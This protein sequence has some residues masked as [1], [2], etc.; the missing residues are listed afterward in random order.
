MDKALE[1]TKRNRELEY[2][3]YVVVKGAH[4]VAEPTNPAIGNLFI[5]VINTGRTPGLNGKVVSEVEFQENPPPEST[6]INPP[7]Q[8]PSKSVFAP[9]IEFLKLAGS[10]PTDEARKIREA[11]TQQRQA[12]SSESPKRAS[13]TPRPIPSPRVYRDNRKI[14]VYGKVEYDD[15]FGK[16]HETKFCFVNSPGTPIWWHCQTFN[17]AN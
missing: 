2:R 16:H 10:L 13:T 7:D 6:V 9:Q 15:I 8:T 5:T 1:E 12:G 3:A 17:D 4:L 11:E 14:F